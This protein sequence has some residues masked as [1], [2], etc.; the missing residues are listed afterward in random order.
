M[1]DSLTSVLER[2]NTHEKMIENYPLLLD[3]VKQAANG[4]C[5]ACRSDCLRCDAANLLQ[6]CGESE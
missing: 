6:E 5:C 3:F 1:K 4:S 2:I